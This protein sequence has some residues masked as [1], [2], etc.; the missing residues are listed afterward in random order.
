VK[1][2]AATQRI[3]KSLYDASKRIISDLDSIGSRGGAE[4]FKEDSVDEA[5]T[6]DAVKRI[7]QLTQ[8]K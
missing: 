6:P 4:E 3:K 5:A 7:E 2:P 8:Y 1:D